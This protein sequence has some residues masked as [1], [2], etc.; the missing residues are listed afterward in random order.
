M[1]V[2]IAGRVLSKEI[3]DQEHRR[4]LDVAIRELPA[5]STAN[6]HGGPA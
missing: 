1:A 4:L 2:S 6:G 5:A 3:G